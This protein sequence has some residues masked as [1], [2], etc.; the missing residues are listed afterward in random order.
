MVKLKDGVV[1]SY[2]KLN[3]PIFDRMTLS[4]NHK[5]SQEIKDSFFDGLTLLARYLDDKQI[6]VKTLPPVDIVFLNTNELNLELNL[7]DQ[8]AFVSHMI[9]F[10]TNIMEELNESD[11]VAIVLEEFCHHFFNIQDEVEVCYKVLEV[12]QSTSPHVEL[13]DVY[14]IHSIEGRKRDMGY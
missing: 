9:V 13:Y 3:H 12:I 7:K 10:R 8:Y 4:Q 2:R 1:D 5:V 14:S 6:A 11:L